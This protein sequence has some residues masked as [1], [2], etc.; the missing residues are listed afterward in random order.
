MTTL[1][2]LNETDLRA[3][4]PESTRETAWSRHYRYQYQMSHHGGTTGKEYRASLCGH[5]NVITDTLFHQSCENSLNCL[6][7]LVATHLTATFATSILAPPY[8]DS[9]PSIA[10]FG[11]GNLQGCRQRRP[12][13]A[14]HE[15][16]CGQLQAGAKP[17]E[18]PM[19]APQKLQD[20]SQRL[21]VYLEQQ[22]CVTLD[23]SVFGC[24]KGGKNGNLH[25]PIL[26]S[27]PQSQH[28]RLG[29]QSHQCRAMHSVLR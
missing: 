16:R 28:A 26:G 1:V 18:N 4:A 5:A 11:Q 21:G 2:I 22:L 9:V 27:I 10:Y 13:Q 23:E 15:Q 20:F 17:S 8:L 7:I 6:E 29:E 25:S 24:V 14:V 12:S 3:N 19:L